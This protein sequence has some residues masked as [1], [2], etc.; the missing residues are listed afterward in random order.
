MSGNG[1]HHTYRQERGDLSRY[2]RACKQENCW[3]LG[4]RSV[5]LQFL[6]LEIVGSA[7]NRLRP[8]LM[9]ISCMMSTSYITIS[10]CITRPYFPKTE[11]REE[12][13]FLSRIL[14]FSSFSFHLIFGS[15]PSSSS[16]DSNSEMWGE[17]AQTATEQQQQQQQHGRRP[18]FG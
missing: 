18:L 3:P 5:L 8:S 15:R 4:T 10:F 6:E 12:L 13:I 11:K 9:H 1:C 17:C 16:S 2:P 7:S 14:L